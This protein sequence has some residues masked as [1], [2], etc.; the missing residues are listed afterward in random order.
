PHFSFFLQ[1]HFTLATPC[2]IGGSELFYIHECSQLKDLAFKVPMLPPSSWKGHFRYAAT[3]L[4]Q[5][6]EKEAVVERLFGAGAEEAM[7][8]EEA[9]GQGRLRFYPTFFDTIGLDLINPHSRRTKAG[10]VPILEEIA[11]P[12]AKGVLSL[13]YIP[14]DL[15]GG[16]DLDKAK[17]QVKEDLFFTYAILKDVLH[18]YGFSAKNARGF[19]LAQYKY[20]KILNGGK[21]APGGFLEMAGVPVYKEAEKPESGKDNTFS[22]LNQLKRIVDKIANKL[23]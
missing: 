3:R 15:L 13:L 10:T 21:E 1:I 4:I 23:S 2:H 11:T 5:E 6:G 18:T 8:K 20:S 7:E 19:G 12:G 22:Y 17:K 16:L 14:V 9:L